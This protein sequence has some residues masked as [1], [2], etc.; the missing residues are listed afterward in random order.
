MPGLDQDH[1]GGVQAQS[2]EAVP[3]R[4]AAVGEPSL[5]GN[6]QR[7]PS[8]RHAA[9]QGRHEAEGGRQGVGR[10]RRHLVQGPESKATQRQMAIE[11]GQPKW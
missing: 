3:V 10:F 8:R 7:R 11:S 2:V 9:K 4:A 5:R 1:A 6:K